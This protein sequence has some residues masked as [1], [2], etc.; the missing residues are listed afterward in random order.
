MSAAQNVQEP[1]SSE[2]K[3]TLVTTIPPIKALTLSVMGTG[4]SQMRDPPHGQK[5]CQQQTIQVLPIHDPTGFDVEAA[6]FAILERGFHT[7]TPRVELDL[8]VSCASITD[9]QPWLF[10]LRV[11]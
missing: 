9:Q 2:P 3:N 8:S 4:C 6:A 11:P 5:Q 1:E 10:I 7:H